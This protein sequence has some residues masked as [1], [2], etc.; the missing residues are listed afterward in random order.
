MKQSLSDEYLI[1]C[2]KTYIKKNNEVPTRKKFTKYNKQVANAIGNRWGWNEGIRKTGFE[3][4]NIHVKLYKQFYR[5]DINTMLEMTKLV[6]N[7]FLSENKRLP[8]S[9]EFE[10]L[11]MPYFRFYYEKYRCTYTEFLIEICGYDEE[12]LSCISKNKANT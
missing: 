7:E 4:K 9:R 10:K 8:K 6:I 1:E 2:L 3:P 11:D 5:V 12:F